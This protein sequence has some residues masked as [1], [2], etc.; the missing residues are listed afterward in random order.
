[1]TAID[2]FNFDGTQVRTVMI[3][4]EPWFVAADVCTVLG[5]ANSRDALTRLDDDEKGVANTDTLGGT[6][7][8]SIVNEPG[9]YGLTWTSRK[10]QAARLRRWVK[11]DVLPSIRKTGSYGQA[12]ALTGKELLA[13]AVIE[14]NQM[15]AEKDQQ[16]AQLA[17]KANAFDGYLGAEGDYS[18][19]EAGKLLQ[20]RGVETGQYKLVRTL[21]DWKWI[22]RGRKNTPRAMQAQIDTGRLTEKTHYFIDQDTGEKRAG[23]TQVRI[24]PKGVE[25]IY[26]RITANRLVEVGA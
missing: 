18:F 22:Y 26:Q 19:N 4:N 17:P 24:T 12:P 14:A 9:L 25:D 2:T 8:V 15:I 21:L 10:P 20:R 5:I 16:I 23:A 13:R 11:H 1:M 7:K 3:D 6:Q